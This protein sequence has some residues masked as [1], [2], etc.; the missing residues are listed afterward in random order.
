M[1]WA[2]LMFGAKQN[3]FPCQGLRRHKIHPYHNQNSHGR[4][5]SFP[6]NRVC[7]GGRSLHRPRRCLHHCTPYQTQVG[8]EL[9]SWIVYDFSKTGTGNWETIPTYHGTIMTQ[10]RR[11]S[12]PAEKPGQAYSR[13]GVHVDRLSQMLLVSYDGCLMDWAG[14]PAFTTGLEVR[15]EFHGFILF[16][17]C[18]AVVKT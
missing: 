2:C 4:Q 5:K 3:R 10:H 16:I 15:Y 11:E 13:P 8:A 17:S 18:A 14:A 6:W 12:Q 7:C 9:S 1:P